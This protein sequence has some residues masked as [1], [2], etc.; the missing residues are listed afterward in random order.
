MNTIFDSRDVFYRNPKYAVSEN[1]PIHFK[2]VL[3]RSIQCSKAT[4]KVIADAGNESF[5]NSMF[6]CGMKDDN[7]EMWECDFTPSTLGLYWYDFEIETNEGTKSIKR[8]FAD[9]RAVIG[10]GCSWQITVTTEDFKTPDWLS[11]GIMYQIFPDRFF[12]SGKKKTLVPKDRTIRKDWGGVPEFRPDENNKVTNSDYFGGDLKGIQEKLDYIE[13]LGVNCIYLNPIFEAH[14]NHRYNTADYTKIDP[15]LGTMADF[16]RLC[17]ELKNRGMHLIIDGVFSH[18]GSDSVYFNKEKRYPEDG[19][20]NSKESPYYSWYN[21]L[22]WPDEYQSW[23]GFKTLPE[24][25]ENNPEYNKFINGEDGIVRKWIKEGAS[26]WRL[27]V[28]DELPDAFI[29]NLREAVKSENPDALILGEVW[30][31]AS[32]KESYFHRRKFLLGNQLDSVM[33]YPF[34]NAILGFLRGEDGA[35]KIEEI[36]RIVENYPSQ[37]TRNLMNPLGTHDT[38]RALTA[39]V[40]EPINGRDRE[41]QASQSIPE[42]EKAHGYRLLKTAAAM[43]FTLPGIPCIYYGDET[44]M[45]GYKDPFNRGCY[46]WG[47]ENLD[48][49]SWYKDL[50]AMRARCPALKE[51]DIR[52]IYSDQDVIIFER[53][54]EK[55]KSSLLC[56]FNSS[57]SDNRIIIPQGF[58]NGKAL[59]N[60][61]VEDGKLIIPAYGCAFIQVGKMAAI[62]RKP[63]KKATASRVSAKKVTAKNSKSTSRAKNVAKKEG[64]ALEQKPQVEPKE[65]ESKVEKII[66]DALNVISKSKEDILPKR[67]EKALG[68]KPQVEPKEVE[69]KVEKIIDDAL[70]VISKPKEDI[71][72]KKEEVLEQRP[73]IEA[74]VEV[75]PKEEIK[76]NIEPKV[77]VTNQE[78]ATD[79]NQPII[80]KKK[81]R[82][83]R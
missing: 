42:H 32:N 68:Q 64:K 15:L 22:N 73:N 60:T 8:N 47:E 48:M 78:K 82:K 71:L 41:W 11:G 12:N 9:N 83:R 25:E 54:D 36:L 1:T 50:A 61:R 38:E 4:L 51:G 31:D 58:E 70:N 21:F 62:K 59:L 69:S 67:E 10:E 24:I 3:P 74:N 65:V 33:N 6:W 7:H 14:S 66:D 30:E 80:P 34:K 19:A 79:S 77:L 56:A 27:D 52:N 43:Q 45:E 81:K 2:I 35:L 16:N 26:G 72:P 39:L 46:P 57:G 28:A 20:Y 37:V 13:S 23:W 29:E 18:T 40:G 49:I 55:L 53:K 44:A 17:K 76:E 75:K 5:Q 63:S